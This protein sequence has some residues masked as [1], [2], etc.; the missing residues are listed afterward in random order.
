[1]ITKKPL[2]A[3]QTPELPAE[4]ARDTSKQIQE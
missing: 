4:S 1:M 3:V 2:V